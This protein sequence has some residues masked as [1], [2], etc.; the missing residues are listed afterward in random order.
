MKKPQ[1]PTTILL[2]LYR[3]Q[4]IR[5]HIFSWLVVLAEIMDLS[6]P[7]STTTT[8]NLDFKSSTNKARMHQIT[9]RGQQGTKHT[10]I[11]SSSPLN[12]SRR[13]RLSTR[14]HFQ[15]HRSQLVSENTKILVIHHSSI[16]FEDPLHQL[17]TIAMDLNWS[18]FCTLGMVMHKMVSIFRVF[19]FALWENIVY[20]LIWAWMFLCVFIK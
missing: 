2:R 12:I 7:N 3:P 14:K 1:K 10:P 15:D 8:S 5:H 19:G 13:H 17:N 6:N 11:I 9:Q 16:T 20:L 18:R 4:S